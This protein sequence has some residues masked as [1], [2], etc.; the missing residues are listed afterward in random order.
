MEEMSRK[1]RGLQSFTEPNE[2]KD[3]G[4]VTQI[5]TFA[6]R[7]SEFKPQ[8]MQ[9]ALTIIEDRLDSLDDL[10]NVDQKAIVRLQ[11]AYDKIKAALDALDPALPDVNAEDDVQ[12]QVI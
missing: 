7:V 4:F 12:P 2:P 9:K 1:E 6:S 10:D 8:D 11:V 5:E 3:L